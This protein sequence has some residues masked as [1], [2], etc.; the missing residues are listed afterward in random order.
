MPIKATEFWGANYY[1]NPPVLDANIAKAEAHF[2][3]RLPKLYL[4]LIRIQNGGY[5]QG[6]AF[7]TKKP[8][9]WAADHVPFEEMAGIVFR[10]DLPMHSIMVTDYMIK[11]WGLPAD[12]ILLAG[13]GHTWISLDYRKRTIP[14]IKWIDVECE[15]EHRFWRKRSRSSTQHSFQNLRLSNDDVAGGKAIQQEFAGFSGWLGN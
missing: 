4:D 8:T 14:A 15:D 12:Q 10:D 6:L 2:G 13:D 1:N 7:P 11:G 3:K 9:S 5:T